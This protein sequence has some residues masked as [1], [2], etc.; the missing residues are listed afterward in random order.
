MDVVLSYP[1][2]NTLDSDLPFQLSFI[3]EARLLSRANVNPGLAVSCTITEDLAG[4][5]AGSGRAENTVV[6][7]VALTVF[8]SLFVY[9]TFEIHVMTTYPGVPLASDS[10]GSF[11]L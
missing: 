3:P 9:F 2:A 7:S 4:V 10:K 5:K 8:L 1:A 11:L 6:N